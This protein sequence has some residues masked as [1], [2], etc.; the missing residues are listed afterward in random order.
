MPK[1]LSTLVLA[2]LLVSSLS[3]CDAQRWVSTIK[4][5]VAAAHA[6]SRLSP[7][8]S[9]SGRVEARVLTQVGPMPLA[10]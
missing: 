5:P 9:Q 3:G 8:F 6:A 10:R 7:S 1:L 2:T 4:A